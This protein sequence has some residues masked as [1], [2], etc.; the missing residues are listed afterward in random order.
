[1]AK[2]SRLLS[3]G[4][5]LQ[6]SAIVLAFVAFFFPFY[7]INFS[8]GVIDNIA[9][10]SSKV[11][12]KLSGYSCEFTNSL[13]S[14]LDTS[15]SFSYNDD[16]GIQC[17]PILI[18]A[19]DYSALSLVMNACLSFLILGCACSLFV[20]LFQSIMSCKETCRNCCM[21]IVTFIISLT[22]IICFIIA[23]FCLMGITTVFEK[24]T[25][26]GGTSSEVNDLSLCQGLWCNSF[27]G[28]G[29]AGTVFASASVNWKPSIGWFLA[30]GAG[31]ASLLACFF[32]L[33]APRFKKTEH[34]HNEHH[35]DSNQKYHILINQ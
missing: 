6:L 20:I 1:M 9:S 16:A 2:P 30:I 10:T 11:T 23:V 21:K 22:P 28:S 17:I 19:G 35:R 26:P 31:F 5:V 34:H 15:A 27:Y 24:Q 13:D 4:I 18:P 12:F 32:T 25:N 7:V 33:C 29:S 8:G 14:S 3:F